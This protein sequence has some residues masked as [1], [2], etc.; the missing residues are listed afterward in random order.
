MMVVS[1]LSGRLVEWWDCAG[2]DWYDGASRLMLLLAVD[3]WH[4]SLVDS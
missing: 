1:W 3:C 4:G 2:I